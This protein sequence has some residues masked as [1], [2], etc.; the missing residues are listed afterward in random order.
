MFWSCIFHY[1]DLENEAYILVAVGII[2]EGDTKGESLS[3][4]WYLLRSNCAQYFVQVKVS[5]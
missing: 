3:L 1:K 2:T 5:T 4:N